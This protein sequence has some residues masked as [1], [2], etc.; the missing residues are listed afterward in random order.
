MPNLSKSKFMTGCQCV[1]AL[2]LKLHHPELAEP[3]SRMKQALFSRGHEVGELA[4]Q[5]FPD[6]YN[7]KKYGFTKSVPYTRQLL[8]EGADTIYEATFSAAGL[9][10]MVDILTKENGRWHLYEVKSS[11]SV[12]EP[13][14]LDTAVQYYTLRQAGLDMDTA[15]LVHLNTNYVR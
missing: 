9:F 11:A 10:V 15:S 4:Q 3:P 14:Y 8:Q 7:A 12:K 5:L 1:K 2:Y 13:H 6:G